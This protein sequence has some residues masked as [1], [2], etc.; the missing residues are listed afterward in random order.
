MIPTEAWTYESGSAVEHGGH[1][2]EGLFKAAGLLGNFMAF[3]DTS[4]VGT[5]ETE[6]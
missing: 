2:G 3:T 1:S 5:W 4:K 6:A